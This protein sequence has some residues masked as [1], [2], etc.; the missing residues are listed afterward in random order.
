MDENGYKFD[1]KVYQSRNFAAVYEGQFRDGKR[2][3]TGTL[4]CF[5]DG[6]EYR[7]KWKDN[8]PHPQWWSDRAIDK[9]E[10]MLDFPPPRGRPEDA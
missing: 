2:S 1:K 8:R 7:G 9:N 4:T 3:S 5:N 6:G 10:K